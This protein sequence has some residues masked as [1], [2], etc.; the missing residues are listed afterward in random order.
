MLLSKLCPTCNT[1]LKYR[2]AH[3][4]DYLIC[5]SCNAKFTESKFRMGERKF[6]ETDLFD[7]AYYAQKESVEKTLIY[8]AGA[9][10]KMVNQAKKALNQ[11]RLYKFAD[12][13]KFNIICIGTKKPYFDDYMNYNSRIKYLLKKNNLKEENCILSCFSNG[14]IPTILCGSYFNFEKICFIS[15]VLSDFLFQFCQ[16]VKSD[17][18]VIVNEKDGSFIPNNRV[19]INEL[20]KQSKNV[21]V[22]KVNSGHSSVKSFE[23][24]VEF[25]WTK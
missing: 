5:E 19:L 4:V 1:A 9:N 23:K 10:I 13:Y 17:I 25:I 22:I 16:Q 3:F 11:S 15:P 20:K 2:Y 21:D 12:E 8:F 24:L 18:L 14:G 7:F 6:E